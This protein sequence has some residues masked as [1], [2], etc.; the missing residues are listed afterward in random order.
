[1]I[2]VPARSADDALAAIQLVIRDGEHSMI[3]LD[4]DGRVW[5]RVHAS[6]V[7]AVR[8]YLAGLR[9]A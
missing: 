7:N 9:A 6:L 2:G 5:A 4:P 8:D 3:E 1:M